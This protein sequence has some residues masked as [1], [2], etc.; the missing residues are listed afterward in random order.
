[1]TR[2]GKT[3]VARLAVAMLMTA[4][5]A[6]T[7]GAAEEQGSIQGFL[8]VSYPGDLSADVML[9]SA[10]DVALLANAG[11][12]EDEIAALKRQRVAELQA[13]EAVA[14][15]AHGEARRAAGQDKVKEKRELLK[16]ESDKF[17]KLRSQYQKEVDVLIAKNTLRK[18]RT[19]AE[20][21]F[22]FEAVARGRYLVSARF[23]VRGTDSSYF[24]LYPVDVKPEG[25]A[26][27]QLSKTTA[28]P[29][30]Q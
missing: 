29:L 8:Y 19:D 24:W 1:M 26:E 30:Y 28:L 13:Q 18:T 10:V 16:R 2:Y 27:A 20:G 5:G 23:E 7:S 11:N 25:T 9:G 14:V 6:K 15:K 4:I 17:D 12:V 22:R 21:K 3:L